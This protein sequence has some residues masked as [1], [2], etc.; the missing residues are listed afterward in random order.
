MPEGPEVKGK[1]QWLNNKIKN[2]NLTNIKILGGRYKRHG[3]PINFLK[4]KK[5]LP[6]KIKSI[7][8]KGKFIWW[9]FSN[10]QLSLWNTLGMS[11]W[12]TTNSNIKHNNILFEFGK[13]KIYFN[14]TRNFGTIK[15]CNQENL[16]KKLKCLGPDVLNIKKGDFE[17][18]LKRIERKRNDTLICNALIDQKVISGI[19]NY[20]RA[21]ILWLSKISPFRSIK[22]LSKNELKKIFD[23]SIKLANRSF[24]IQY[25]KKITNKDLIHPSLGF[26]FFFIYGKEKD[27]QGNKVSRK[28]VGTRTIHY[29]SKVQK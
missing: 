9:E 19:G 2:R 24:K 20:M 8:S 4:L 13:T 22:N 29:V 11:G 27:P 28:K 26:R 25:S 18:F 6:L 10:S 3:P 15:I 12:W 1:V 23:N 7:N 5:L 21:D 16:D 17:V 14:D